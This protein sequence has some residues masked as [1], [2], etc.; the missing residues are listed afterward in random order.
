M[1]NK[2]TCSMK[3]SNLEPSVY[4]AV[5]YISTYLAIVSV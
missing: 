3:G 4:L 5:V 2:T 1:E